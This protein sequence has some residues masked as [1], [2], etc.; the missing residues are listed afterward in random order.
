MT[1]CVHEEDP[2]L[3]PPCQNP[4]KGRRLGQGRRTFVARYRGWC[5]VC[6]D[7][8]EPGDRVRTG[9]SG[10]VVCEPCA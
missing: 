7:A 3:C 2:N 5:S 8:I 1:Y 4:P 9:A 6:G 10:G